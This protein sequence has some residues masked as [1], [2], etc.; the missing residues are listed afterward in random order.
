MVWPR[1]GGGGS[2]RRG[3]GVDD[4]IG[5]SAG[6]GPLYPDGDLPWS[7]LVPIM[8]ATYS[9]MRGLVAFVNRYQRRMWDLHQKTHA[10]PVPRLTVGLPPHLADRFPAYRTSLPVFSAEI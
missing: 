7:A 5:T 1:A 2:R 10:A 3:P 4:A 8:V 9:G 6:D